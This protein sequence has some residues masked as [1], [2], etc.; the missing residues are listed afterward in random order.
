MKHFMVEKEYTNREEITIDIYLEIYEK[1]DVM[2]F[3]M[4]PPLRV[5]LNDDDSQNELKKVFVKILFLMTKNKIKLNYK[6][7]P[8]YKTGLYI[9]VCREYVKSLDREIK[10][11]AK[12]MP[13]EISFLKGENMS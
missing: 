1:K 12:S 13:K 3:D 5:S 9:D 10:N 4:E 2:V 8:E 6:E 7:N 11:V